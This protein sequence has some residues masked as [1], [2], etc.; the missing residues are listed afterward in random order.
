[1]LSCQRYS[2]LT[3]TLFG[4]KAN[5]ATFGARQPFLGQLAGKN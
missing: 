3:K 4:L 5:L 1:M 2:F